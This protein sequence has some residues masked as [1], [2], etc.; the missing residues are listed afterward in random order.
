MI[1]KSFKVCGPTILNDL[2]A[3]MK[4]SSLSFDS[5]RKLLKTFLFDKWLLRERICGSCINLRGE[6]FIII[7]IIKS[8]QIDWESSMNGLKDVCLL[9]ANLMK[10]LNRS[11]NRIT[12]IFLSS[13]NDRFNTLHPTINIYLTQPNLVCA[14]STCGNLPTP[15][16]DAKSVQARTWRDNVNKRQTCHIMMK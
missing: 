2:P 16:L 1:Y 8:T 11:H 5:F 13:V 15:V 10:I 7:I 9:W 12:F 3:R 14:I 6:M 4:D